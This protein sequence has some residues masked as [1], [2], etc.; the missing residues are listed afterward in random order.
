MP[1]Y[2]QSDGVGRVL[3][4]LSE[5]TA[6]TS[7]TTSPYVMEPSDAPDAGREPPADAKAGAVRLL[8]REL[9]GRRELMVRAAPSFVPDKSLYKGL[10]YQP[11]EP[12]A[13]TQREGHVI[14]SFVD[15][16]KARG[17][18]AYMQV[19]SAIPPG[20]RVQF[21]GALAGDRSL[22]PDG[23]EHEGRVD[24]NGSLA[25][26]HIIEYGCAL[27]RD[28]IQTYPNLDGLRVDWPEYPPYA[29]DSLFFDFSDIIS[30]YVLRRNYHYILPSKTICWQS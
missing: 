4:N 21:G 13:L 1:E 14:S 18:G 10:R 19:Q 8:G 28:I 22:L 5:R 27:L 7:I 11:S 23:T 29:F 26:P 17:V 9:W 6:A 25:S 15:Q 24:K 3:D 2:P 12:G 16:A 30:S 20:Y